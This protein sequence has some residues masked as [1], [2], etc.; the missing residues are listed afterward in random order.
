[1]KNNTLSDLYKIYFLAEKGNV[2]TLV[3][4]KRNSSIFPSVTVHISYEN[5]SVL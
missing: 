5:R 3:A 4:Q 2:F 1:M